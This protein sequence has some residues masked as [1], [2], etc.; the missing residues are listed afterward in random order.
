MTG[1]CGPRLP[2]WC[3]HAR[4]ACDGSTWTSSTS[5]TSTT[6][7]TRPRS[8]SPSP[9]WRNFVTAG[10]IRAIGLSNVTIDD[11]RRAHAVHPVAALQEQWSLVAD[12]AE[13]FLPTLAELGITL[14][15]HSPLG[16]G[17]LS[18]DDTP[19]DVRAALA[20]PAARLDARP[21]QVALAW[22]HH[23]QRRHGQRVVPLPG[24]TS[25]GHLRANAAAASIALTDGELEKLDV[26]SAGGTP[27]P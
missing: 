26:V 2:P 20:E 6:A 15:A 5:T 4:R 19:A 1:A 8:R 16:H 13:V 22:V 14:V 11:V 25:I 21:G 23:Q 7:A 3:G 18:G 17:R 27:A 10:K 9:R 24:A 12:A